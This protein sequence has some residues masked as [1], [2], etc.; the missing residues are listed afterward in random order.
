MIGARMPTDPRQ[1]PTTSD[2]LG[3]PRTSPELKHR[4]LLGG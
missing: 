2:Y 3:E 4:T 1:C